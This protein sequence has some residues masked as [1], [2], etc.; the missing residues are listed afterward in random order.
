MKAAICRKF[1]AL[2]PQ[3]PSTRGIML[4]GRRQLPVRIGSS[5]PQS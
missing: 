2:V 5:V 3:T 1:S 4:G